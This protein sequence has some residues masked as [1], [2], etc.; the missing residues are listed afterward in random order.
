MTDKWLSLADAQAQLSPQHYAHLADDGSLTRRVRNACA[1]EFSVQLIE[2]TVVEPDSQERLI[3]NIQKPTGAISRQV[4]L[5]CDMR[6]VIFARTLIGL[7]ENNRSLTD[8]IS[9]LGTKS[10]GS[11]LFRDPLARKLTLHLALIAGSDVFFK[12][13]KLSLQQRSDEFWVR[14]NLYDYEGCE[15]IV[16]EAYID[17][18][19]MD[20]C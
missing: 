8:R 14:R 11:V 10:L 9:T 18:E 1:G 12:D 4:F 13:A 3:L 2:H 16:Y 17:F 7:S 15:L 19:A 20:E 6:P 5:C